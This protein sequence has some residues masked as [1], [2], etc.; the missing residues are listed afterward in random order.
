MDRTKHQ[1][2]RKVENRERTWDH[3]DHGLE[4]PCSWAVQR[5][6]R[7][8]QAVLESG[9]GGVAVPARSMA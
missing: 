2:N 8:T 3:S 4:V 1:I 5:G 7:T 6:T 9:S